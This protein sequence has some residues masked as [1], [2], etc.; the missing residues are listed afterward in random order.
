[1]VTD[2]RY[3]LMNKN[4]PV[5]AFTYDT[6]SHVVTK[7]TD[8]YDLR[9]APPIVV[10]QKGDVTKKAVNDW[11]RGRAIP[12]SRDQIR[13][14]VDGLSIDSTLALAEENFGLSLSDRYWVNDDSNPQK[15]SDINFF[16]NDFTDDLGLLTLGQASSGNPN[17]MSPNSTLNGDLKKKWTIYQGQRILVKEG[18][19]FVNQEV[20]N[21]V[22]AT[23]LHRRLLDTSDFVPYR[24]HY[25]K[26][27][28]Y[29]AC[30]NMLGEDEELVP[31]WDLIANKKKPNDMSNCQFLSA[32]FK[33]LGVEDVDQKLSKMFTCDFIL[34]NEDRHYRNFGV[35]RNVET[36]E[37]T[38]VAPIF[39]TG[40]CLWCRTGS[41]TVPLD[42]R[43]LA[44]PFGR[45]GA[46]PA[47]QL[48][49]FHEYSWFDAG[50][51]DGF[52]DEA[53]EILSQNE[54]IAPR[55]LENVRLGLEKN[56]AHVLDYAAGETGRSV[57]VPVLSHLKD[58][59]DEQP[60][61]LQDRAQE[62]KDVH[63]TANTMAAA[64]SRNKGDTS[65]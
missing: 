22:I 20:Y 40:T 62:T 39:D 41:L 13:N 56:I 25:E 61:P 52:A 32:V 30:P 14:L 60:L 42:Y 4:T 44:K 64:P 51:L 12:A 65:R 35:I 58:R 48:H 49:M 46:D 2:A 33:E 50:K 15:W 37:Y 29:C 38:R 54:N 19:G 45:E 57:S 34:A 55:R 5:L 53:M 24:F 21:E 36:L 59:R 11:W 16:D 27:K 10:G 18:S 28:R 17:L 3:V 23:Q 47:R 7:I 6:D 63:N 1:M 26:G 8:V 31:A 9:Y 43:Y